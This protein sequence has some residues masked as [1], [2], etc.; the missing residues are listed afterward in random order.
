M[1]KGSWIEGALRAFERGL[2]FE[3]L[4]LGDGEPDIRSDTH[5]NKLATFGMSRIR[6]A[7]AFTSAV[8]SGSGVLLR[9]G[10]SPN[11]RCNLLFWY[12]GIAES[13]AGAHSWGVVEPSDC[14]SLA[15]L[16]R[17]NTAIPIHSL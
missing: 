14:S 10:E 15:I 16:G 17:R 7:V 2:G 5:K 6:R 8:R 11:R 13:W 1:A 4:A 9:C 3:G 12:S